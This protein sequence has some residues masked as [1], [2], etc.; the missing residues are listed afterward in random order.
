[1]PIPVETLPAEMA[2]K[3]LLIGV[4]QHVPPQVFLIL[5][6]KA[7]LVALVGP[8]AGVLCHVGPDLG[9]LAGTEGAVGAL[10]GTRSSM[11]PFMTL[12]LSSTWES[13]STDLAGKLL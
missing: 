5:G 6:G 8:Q 12:H 10:E 7:A 1:M 9:P 2:C 11:G 4:G 13:L 3:R